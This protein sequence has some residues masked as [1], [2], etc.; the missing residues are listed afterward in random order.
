[1]SSCLHNVMVVDDNVYLPNGTLPFL[2]TWVFA[3]DRLLISS[4][5]QEQSMM[6]SLLCLPAK[7]PARR[8]AGQPTKQ[9]ISKPAN[10]TTVDQPIQQLI[11]PKQTASQSANQAINQST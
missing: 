7:Q 8:P 2:S 10:Q 6:S 4:E 1:M 3:G 11:S 5:F 9:P